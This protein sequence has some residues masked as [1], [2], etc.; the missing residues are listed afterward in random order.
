MRLS[1]ESR[2]VISRLSVHGSL[3]PGQAKLPDRGSWEAGLIGV[4]AAPDFA[5]SGW[6]YLYYSPAGPQPENRLSRFTLRGDELE[7][8]SER[9]LL[10]V[11]VQREVCCHDAGSLAFDGAG[12]LFLSTGDN[13]NPFQSHTASMTLRPRNPVHRRAR[14]TGSVV[15]RRWNDLR[16]RF[17]SS[18]RSKWSWGPMARST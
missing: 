10:R 15:R 3:N 14:P 8:A 12:N 7:L 5:R 18:A 1:A 2:Y 17:R 6:I 16:P 9:I 4:T 11:P 13:T